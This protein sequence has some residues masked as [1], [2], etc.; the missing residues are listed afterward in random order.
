MRRRNA[1][2]VQQGAVQVP[3]DL[4]RFFSYR[5]AA[6]NRS[7]VQ[8]GERYFSRTVGLSIPEWRVVAM[9]GRDGELA[10]S[11]LADAALLDPGQNSRV[12]ARLVERGILAQRSDPADGRRVL[13]RLTPRGLALF[14]R[15]IGFAVDRQAALLGALTPAEVAA[16]DRILDKLMNWSA[17]QESET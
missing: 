5:L 10:A 15:T 16:L 2:P 1:K 6:V 9:L 13:L 3:A 11:T 14:N 7:L 4:R 12:T 8:Q 17:D